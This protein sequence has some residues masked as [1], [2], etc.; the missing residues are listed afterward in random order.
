MAEP[1]RTITRTATTAR[2]TS[3][4]PVSTVG[5]AAVEPLALATAVAPTTGR[6]LLAFA[7]HAAVAA[8]ARACRHCARLPT[9][10]PAASPPHG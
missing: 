7:S 9:A 4:M 6:P 1:G 10:W 2:G 5:R 8:S 3:Q